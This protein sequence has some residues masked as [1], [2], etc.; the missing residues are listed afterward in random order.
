MCLACKCVC[1][2]ECQFVLLFAYRKCKTSTTATARSSIIVFHP[3][4]FLLCG[5]YTLCVCAC[6][7]FSLQYPFPLPTT[8][9]A[10]T[11]AAAEHNK[12]LISFAFIY[13]FL[14]QLHYNFLLLQNFSPSFFKALSLSAYAA[15]S[16]IPIVFCCLC[17]HIG[18]HLSAVCVRLCVC[19]CCVNIQLVFN[20]RN[21]Y[22]INVL[23]SSS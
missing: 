11:A 3:V 12:F 5:V 7:C 22:L 16:I 2:C 8:L 15:S 14:P 17:C 19:V 13:C 20:M 6:V 10:A 4:L 21:A 23:I 18:S 1:A 9:A